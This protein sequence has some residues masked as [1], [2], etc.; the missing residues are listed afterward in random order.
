MMDP[1][2][3]TDDRI[4]MLAEQVTATNDRLDNLQGGIA[5]LA[6]RIDSLTDLV[7]GMVTGHTQ[8]FD[9]I[10]RRLEK[11]EMERVR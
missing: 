10:E 3:S 5:D 9:S 11:M 2:L 1:S 6:R 7:Q 8:R 4:D